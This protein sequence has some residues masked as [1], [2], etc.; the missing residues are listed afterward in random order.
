MMMM[1]GLVGIDSG[2]G[3]GAAHPAMLMSPIETYST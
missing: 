1:K 3:G 2:W